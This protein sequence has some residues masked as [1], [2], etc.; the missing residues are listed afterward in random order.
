MASMSVFFFFLVLPNFTVVT[1]PYLLKKL[2]RN[3]SFFFYVTK[4]IEIIFYF[5]IVIRIGFQST[6]CKYKTMHV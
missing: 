2:E 5:H 3:V 4:D 1:D 6:G